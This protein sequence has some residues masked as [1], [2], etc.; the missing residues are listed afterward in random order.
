MAIPFKSI[1][2]NSGVDQEMGHPAAPRDPPQ[3]RVDAPDA[4]AASTGGARSG[5]FR[6]SRAATLVGLDLP[7]ASKNIE[8]KPYGIARV[9][10]D[11]IVGTGGHQRP[12]APT[13]GID[14]EVRASPR[15]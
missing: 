9:T 2:Y 5:I 6:V 3:E 12:R 14:A 1:R 13:F 15:T 10:T 7:P 8:L 4:A 11:R